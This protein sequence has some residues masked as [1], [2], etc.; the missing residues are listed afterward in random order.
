MKYRTAIALAAAPMGLFALMNPTPAEAQGSV[1]GEIRCNRLS[2]DPKLSSNQESQLRTLRESAERDNCRAVIATID[3]R[4]AQVAA[5]PSSNSTPPPPAPADCTLANTAADLALISED[6]DRVRRAR[7]SIPSTCRE[8]SR[9]IGEWIAAHA[10]DSFAAPLRT[11]VPYEPVSETLLANDGHEVYGTHYDEFRVRL[12]RGEGVAIKMQS[13]AFTPMLAIG[14]GRLP[15]SFEQIDWTENEERQNQVVL[16]FQAQNEDMTDYVIVAAHV[17]GGENT[18]F[19][20]YTISRESWTPPPPAPP[21]VLTVG[22]PLPGTLTSSDSHTDEGRRL[23]YQT[24]AYQGRAG[25]RLRLSME[26]NDFDAYQYFGR[27]VDG[28]YEILARDDDGGEGVDSLIRFVRLPADGEYLLRARSLGGNTGAYTL[29]VESVPER[30]T[31][32]L[33]LGDTNAWSTRGLL[34][35]DSPVSEEGYWYQDFEIRTPREGTYVVRATSPEFNPVVEVS[36]IT[37]R[38][39]LR[40]IERPEGGSNSEMRFEGGR[41]ANYVVRIRSD[42]AGYGGE[43]DLV[44]AQ[45]PA[46]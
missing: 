30:S 39:G 38:D 33:N 34:L 42:S 23:V 44:V 37:R 40:A 24:W 17:D 2:S 21:Q 46:P 19:G 15:D 36:E 1:F 29:L 12:P 27:M 41:R 22:A 43:F 14:T 3:A 7:D 32:R 9:R 13:E 25:E 45:Q 8:A 20:A 28:Q 31:E 16:H 10:D 35:E 26:S 4:L 5:T 18:R 11:L 6:L